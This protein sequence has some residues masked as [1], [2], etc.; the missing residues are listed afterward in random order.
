MEFVFSHHPFDDTRDFNARANDKILGF[1]SWSFNESRDYFAA[2]NWQNSQFIFRG[3]LTKFT[4]FVCYRLMRFWVF[5]IATDWKILRFFF[6]QPI[7]EFLV[8]LSRPIDDYRG[9]TSRP[10]D[11]IC[12]FISRAIDKNRA[13]T[14]Q[15]MDRI[16]KTFP[17]QLSRIPRQTGEILDFISWTID[18]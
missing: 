4:F 12:G 7:D 6:S 3:R 1:I 18:E 2:I 11:E 16:C 13:F 15:A 9:F 14:S 5:F 10:I 8:S 17:W